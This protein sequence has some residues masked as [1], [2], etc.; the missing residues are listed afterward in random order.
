MVCGQQSHSGPWRTSGSIESISRSSTVTP[1][2]LASRRAAAFRGRARPSS[3]ARSAFTVTPT[4]AATAAWVKAAGASRAF[5]SR[6]ARIRVTVPAGY[7]TRA[8]SEFDS[9]SSYSSSRAILGIVISSQLVL[10][11]KEVSIPHR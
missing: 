11:G 9:E 4:R 3:Q 10:D 7:P 1:S 5:S 8:S 6:I 2:A